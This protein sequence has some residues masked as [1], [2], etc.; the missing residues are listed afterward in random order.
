MNTNETIARAQQQ[1]ERL[2]GLV[3][4]HEYNWL[5][6]IDLIARSAEPQQMAKDLLRIYFDYVNYL[7]NDRNMCGASDVAND[8]YTLRTL[9][10]TLNEMGDKTDFATVIN[11]DV[12]QVCK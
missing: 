12:Q 7:L 8:I 4:R 1:A 11:I 10:E 3:N 5:P 6:I 2:N 9:Y